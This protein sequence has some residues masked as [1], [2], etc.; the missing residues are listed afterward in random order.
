MTGFSTGIGTVCILFALIHQVLDRHKTGGGISQVTGAGDFLVRVHTS[1]TR[2][3]WV[4]QLL[5]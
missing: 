2:F 5:A 1:D 4:L 3:A